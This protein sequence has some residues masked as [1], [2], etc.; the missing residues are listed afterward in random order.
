MLG[1]EGL[2]LGRISPRGYLSLP[3]L[4]RRNIVKPKEQ[5]HENGSLK[6]ARKEGER[7]VCTGG[8]EGGRGV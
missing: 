1:Q 8:E 7:V 3:P 5:R 2:V 4:K 6:Y